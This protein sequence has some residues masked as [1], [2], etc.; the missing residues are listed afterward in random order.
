[1]RAAIIKSE[2]Y[3][4]SVIERVLRNNGIK[5]DS[6][7]K[8]NKDTLL[9][10]NAIIFHEQN[11]IP[12]ISKVI[13]QIILKKTVQVIFV[14]KTMNI[15]RFYNV[16]ND[17]YFTY[18]EEH[19]IEVALPSVIHLSGKYIKEINVLKTELEK[20]EEEILLMKLT[21]KAKRILIHKGLSEEESHNFI[22]QKSMEMR[23][24][25]KTFVNLIIQ[26]KID[27]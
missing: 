26:N 17:M 22:V 13:D 15:G 18:I 9:E 6:I 10:Y 2:G 21:N 20:V 11:N 14:G 4:D 16:I 24:P 19:K 27:I 7:Q 23:V 5:G 8:I 25:K 1:M 3:L 12:N